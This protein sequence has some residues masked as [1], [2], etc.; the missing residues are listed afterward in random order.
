MN[1]DEEDE[2][3]WL[4]QE[5]QLLAELL[6][7]EKPLMGVCLGSQILCEAAGGTPMRAERPE[8]GWLQVE[9][10]TKG[11]KDPLLGPF[12]PRF[13]AFQ[14]H[15]YEAP[16]PDGAE[17]LAESV[18]CPQAYRIGDF[19]WGLQFH[20]E[21]SA[22]DALQWIKELEEKPD[23]VEIEVDFEQLGRDTLAA[24]GYWNEFGRELCGRFIEEASS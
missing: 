4:V 16:P 11:A 6:A 3:P 15:S 22:V 18:V 24:I 20:A 7:A 17:L 23:L 19:A 1:V 10:N 12:A 8:I 21:V 13:T 9:V 5:K 14:Y 2:H